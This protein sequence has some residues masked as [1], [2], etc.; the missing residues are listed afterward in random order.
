M[1]CTKL[2]FKHKNLE[3]NSFLCAQ[4]TI[5]TA[6]IPPFAYLNLETHLLTVQYI[7]SLLRTKI[8]PH[9]SP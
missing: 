4:V 1:I 7:Y 8:P 9:S 6:S 2:M 3:V 5:C